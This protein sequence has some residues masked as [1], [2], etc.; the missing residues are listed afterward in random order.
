M[1]RRV[2]WRGDAGSRRGLFAHFQCINM[3]AISSDQSASRKPCIYMQLEPS[4]SAFA[5]TTQGEP[6][7]DRDATPEARLVPEDSSNCARSLCHLLLGL[8]CRL[9]CSLYE[10]G[11]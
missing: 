5:D 11:L 1:C 2:I 3:H 4:T 9:T 6:D 10:L 7:D 8:P